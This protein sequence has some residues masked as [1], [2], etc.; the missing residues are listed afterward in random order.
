MRGR[1][2]KE[3]GV[4]GL[5]DLRQFVRRGARLLE[6]TRRQQDLDGSGK[7]SCAGCL[8]PRVEQYAP[9]GRGGVGDPVLRQ[10]KQRQ[11]RL[12]LSPA[13]VRAG[14]RGFSL[15]ELTAKSVN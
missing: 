11:T 1:P 9:D 5:G 15:V 13:F 14:V 10:T 6:V 12:R 2:G 4:H 3:R 8:G 7:D